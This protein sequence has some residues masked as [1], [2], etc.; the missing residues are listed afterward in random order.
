MPQLLLAADP[1]PTGLSPEILG[2]LATRA[3]LAEVN[4]PGK[5][6]LVGPDG[7]RAHSDMDVELMRMSA[8]TLESTFVEF[9]EAGR[10]M[11]VGQELRDTVGK[12][13]RQGEEAMMT[14]TGGVNTH[15]GAIWN[16]GLLVIATAGLTSLPQFDQFNAAAITHRAGRLASIADSYADSRPRPGAT[17]RKRYRVG[18]AVS[19]AASGFPHVL[20]TLRGMGFPDGQAPQPPSRDQQLK[21]LLACMSSLDDTCLLH[22]GGAEGLAFVQTG[23]QNLLAHAKPGRPL[24]SDALHDFDQQLTRQDLSAGG[25]ADLLACALFLTSILGAHHANDH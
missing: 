22:R 14:A 18:G 23:A 13:G 25:S 17:A 1:K 9:A 5:P 4:L 2:N 6:G 10:L 12:I 16:L 20:L 11:D 19:E 15:R 24:D 8:R 3:L 7:T 21:G